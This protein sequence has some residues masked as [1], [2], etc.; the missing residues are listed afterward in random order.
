MY[1]V[2]NGASATTSGNYSLY[3]VLG[4]FVELTQSLYLLDNSVLGT[5]FE[6]T[7]GSYYVDADGNEIPFSF[8]AAGLQALAGATY[9]A[10][11]GSGASLYQTA[12]WNEA[13]QDIAQSL[14]E[15]GLDIDFN[16]DGVYDMN[17]INILLSIAENGPVTEAQVQLAEILN[18]QSGSNSVEFGLDDVIMFMN[19]FGN[20]GETMVYG[21]EGS[22]YSW[23]DNDGNQTVYSMDSA[24]GYQGNPMGPNINMFGY[25]NDEGSWVDF[26]YDD[27]TPDDYFG[28]GW[29]ATQTNNNE[30]TS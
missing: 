9:G 26:G 1:N 14:G 13:Y 8:T 17:D 3:G 11:A 27:L 28:P 20:P 12:A 29:S 4:E 25:F 21:Y 16:G 19:F 10:Q 6:N 7:D 2:M 22:S 23:I 30:T 24:T 15:A 5:L 18:Y